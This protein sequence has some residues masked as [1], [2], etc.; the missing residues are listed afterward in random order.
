MAYWNVDLEVRPPV[1]LR[2][3]RYDGHLMLNVAVDEPDATLGERGA[4]FARAL[5]AYDA[6][7]GA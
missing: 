6:G 4:A 1:G 2:A 5:A 3:S 7:G